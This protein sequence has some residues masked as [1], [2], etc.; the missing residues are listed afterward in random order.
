[1]LDGAERKC[2]NNGDVNR[3]DEIHVCF[4]IHDARGDYCKYLGIALVSMLENTSC[5][6]HIHI[7]LDSSVTQN[8]LDRIRNLS[9][10]YK[11]KIFFHKIDNMRLSRFKDAVKIFSIGT[12]FRFFVAEALP[13][14]L[15]RIIYLDDDLVVNLD[16][17]ELWNI[18]LGEDLVGACRDQCVKDLVIPPGPCVQK[19]VLVD[20]YF[21]QGVLILNLE[22]LRKYDNFLELCKNVLSAHPDY[23]FLDQD[24]FN[25]IFN[26]KVKYLPEKFNVFTRYVRKH[27]VKEFDCI[28][29]FSSDYET[30]EDDCWVDRKLFEYWGKSSWGVEMYDFF[31]SYIRE[32]NK[33]IELHKALIQ[34]VYSG[35]RRLLVWGAKSVLR[36]ELELL[37]GLGE[38]IGVYIDSN[39]EI[40]GEHINGRDICSPDALWQEQ[41][42]DAFIVVLSQRYYEDIKSKLEIM[43]KREYE[44]FIDGAVLLEKRK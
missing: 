7:V 11:C 2:S 44:D 35:E 38:K 17:E 26:G 18:D 27:N 3:M 1:M 8:N 37:Y 21:N 10:Q 32:K 33:T 16:I 22:K 39:K 15:E 43:G 25:D 9:N 6:L 13:S 23:R 19:R 36:D 41:Y 29:H 24:V 30:P 20:D 4:S 5:N 40:I 14:S 31:H 42:K 28:L 34:A 12:L